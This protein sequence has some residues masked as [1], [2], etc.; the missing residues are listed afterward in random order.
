M[1][2]IYI[3]VDEK[4]ISRTC[5]EDGESVE[6]KQIWMQ[7]SSVRQRWSQ[8]DR[9]N[10]SDNFGCYFHLS[11]DRKRLGQ[12]KQMNLAKV[13]AC[14]ALDRTENDFF[15]FPWFNY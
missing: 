3:Q 1:G 4:K 5:R 12:R 9:T 13:V 8:E 11:N 10:L 14:F 2:V 15:I 6:V 7:G